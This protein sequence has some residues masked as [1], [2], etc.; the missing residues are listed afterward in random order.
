MDFLGSP[1]GCAR[2]NPPDVARSQGAQCPVEDKHLRKCVISDGS[3]TVGIRANNE[4]M[5]FIT[6]FQNLKFDQ[7]KF[8]EKQDAI[9]LCK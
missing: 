8:Y 6:L 9:K 7:Q 3:A 5:S 4:S 2:R 1:L